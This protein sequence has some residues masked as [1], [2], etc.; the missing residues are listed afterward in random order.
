M[1]KP[2]LRRLVLVPALITL[3]VTLLR[4]TGE[5]LRWSPALFGREAGGGASLVGIVWLIFVFGIYFALRLAH[6]GE[7]PPRLAPAFG[8]PALGFALNTALLAAAVALLP[9]DPVAQLG[10]F[11][12][13]SWVAILVARRGWPAIWRVLLAYG[14]LARIPVLVIMFLAIFGGWDTHYAK[15]RP[16]FPAMG[17]WGLFFWTALLPQMSVWI[18]LTVVLGMLTGAGTLGIRRL[19]SRPAAAATSPAA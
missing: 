14:F 6:E 17:P 5:L 13:G 15:P 12:V 16:D 19:L 7:A 10:L 3:A 11:T 2:P 4:L 1:S 8:W 18:Y 9:R